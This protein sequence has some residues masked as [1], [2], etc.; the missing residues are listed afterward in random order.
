MSKSTGVDRASNIDLDAL[1]SV[2]P[3]LPQPSRLWE[4]NRARGLAQRCREYHEATKKDE[5]VLN[6]VILLVASETNSMRQG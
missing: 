4:E 5:V 3:R 1:R 2:R 6:D